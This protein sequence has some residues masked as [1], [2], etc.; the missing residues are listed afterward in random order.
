MLLLALIFPSVVEVDLLVPHLMQT[1]CCLGLQ[2][3]DG[4]EHHVTTYVNW[5]KVLILY[6]FPQISIFLPKLAC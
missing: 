6:I 4:A 2:D 1:P 3:A 5:L